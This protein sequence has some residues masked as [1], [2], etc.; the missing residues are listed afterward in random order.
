MK[1]EIKGNAN[2]AATIVSIK[3]IIPLEG[4]DNIVGTTILGN[5]VIIGKDTPLHSL[6]IY[7][8]SECQLSDEFVKAN[9]LYRDT[10]LNKDPDSKGGFIE[11]NRRIRCMKLRGNKSDGLF[12]PIASIVPFMDGSSIDVTEGTSFDHIGDFEV[13]RKYFPKKK[14]G[15]TGSGNKNEKKSKIKLSR[16]KDNQFRLHIDTPQLARE[17]DK[18][19]PSDVIDISS[20][21]HGT[22]A[23]FGKVLCNRP[24][25]WYEKAL[26]KL[27]VKIDIA[28][29]D[30]IFSSRKV[31]KNDIL[32]ANPS[33]YYSS[34]IW[35]VVHNEIKDLIPN[36]VTLYGEIVGY[37]PDGGEVQQSYDYGCEKGKHDFY[38]YRM[39]VTNVDGQ[40][41][42]L[43]MIY[44][45]EW[46]K[47]VGLKVVPQLYYGTVSE[48]YTM[49]YEQYRSADLKENTIIR[50]DKDIFI[51]LL[52]QR[53]LERMCDICKNKVPDEGIVLRVENSTDIKVFKY[54]S[55]LFKNY[56]TSLLDKGE[57]NIE[58][59]QSSEEI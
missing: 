32:C 29:Y 48:L 43:P 42:E 35:G 11:A 27:G 40:V 50:Y 57:S 36:G 30:S 7:F 51:E 23:V 47:S 24:L 13:C 19:N 33:G 2:Y 17:I 14:P 56:E 37:L 53:Y 46:C 4:C 31:V 59:E 9:N 3:N 54:K 15:T 18:I 58:D 5:S 44:V 28:Y 55:F 1:L 26:L 38:V 39:T 41:I 20:K 52:S 10:T 6:G 34:D 22:S 21:L 25:K 8:P 16:L 49:L 45:R 12:M